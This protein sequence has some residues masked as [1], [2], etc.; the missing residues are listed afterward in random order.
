MENWLAIFVVAVGDAFVVAVY[1]LLCVQTEMGGQ[2][3]L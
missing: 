1:V 2:L 3:V